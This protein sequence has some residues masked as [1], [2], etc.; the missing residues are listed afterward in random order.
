MEALEEELPK[1]EAR[2]KELEEQM[3]SGSMAVEELM[4]AS[5]EVT[6]LIDE[7]DLKTLRW[8]ELSEKN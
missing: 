1:L 8:M 4:K 3:S 6:A 2:K 5:T 7:I